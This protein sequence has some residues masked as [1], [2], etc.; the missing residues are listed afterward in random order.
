MRPAGC[1]A[2]ILRA[3]AE[4]PFLDRTG[5][6]AITGRSRG[7]VHGAVASLDRHGLCDAVTHASA[8]FPAVERF[9]LTAAGLERLAYG[10][11]ISTDELLR[12][13]PVSERWR[14]ILLERLDAVAAVYRLAAVL[15]G[16]AH[17]ISFQWFRAAPLD[18]VVSLPDGRTVGI[19]RRGHT[20]DRTPF[21]KRMW[22]LR[23]GPLPGAVLVLMPD[24]V[25]LRHSR[26]ML[27]GFPVPLFLAVESDAVSATLDDPVWSPQAVNAAVSL[28]QVLER[29]EPGGE[30]P[31]EAEPQR[32][33]LPGDLA[34]AGPGWRVPDC[35]LPAVLRPA[36]KR[37]IDLIGDWP[38]VSI[39]D[40]AGMTGVS[41]QRASQVVL[42]LEALNL[43]VRPGGAN[44]RL[45]LADRA[46][47]MLARR[48]R[49]SVS[50]ARSRWSAAPLF[51]GEPF[52]WTNVSGRQTRQ[53]L[54]NLA[55]TAAVHA[56]LAAMTTQAAQLEWEVT[57]LDPPRRASRY[58][59]H[60]GG[61]RAV[62]P[63]AFGL[64]SRGDTTW[65]FFLEWERRA[66]RPSTMSARLAPYLRYYSS[67]RPTDDHGA[68]PAVLVVLDDDIAQTHFLRLAREEMQAAGVS[69]PLWVSHREAVEELGPL[70]LAWR[71]PADPE[72]AQYI[73]PR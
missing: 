67:L 16:L 33:I 70:G 3:L 58:F 27:D 26:R 23:Q 60:Q 37:A 53:L 39:K 69:V 61:M 48:D 20:T 71:T 44:G 54:R 34:A 56:F 65:P 17:P 15:S 49:T 59:R 4:M 22:K 12:S 11:G 73:L 7:A 1:E 30:L 2:Q 40:L 68:Q 38:W 57:Q 24:A 14:T 66:V 9:H 32:A 25:R 50:M 6:A 41:P 45:A 13:R 63:D 46:L 19:V 18:A 62:S 64:L 29:L 42:P 52:H 31:V 28:R 35:L 8:H 55:H 5:L 43:V 36:E 21:A 47:A 51:P 72:P 10:E